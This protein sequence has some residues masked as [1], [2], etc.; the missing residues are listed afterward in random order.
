MAAVPPWLQARLDQLRPADRKPPTVAA[1]WAAHAQL[2]L[3]DLGG[4][5][6]PRGTG[7]G[8]KLVRRRSPWLLDVILLDGSQDPR[9]SGR[10][11]VCVV[12]LLDGSDHLTLGHGVAMH[13]SSLR[14]PDARRL[15]ARAALGPGVWLLDSAL[16]VTEAALAL[17]RAGVDDTAERHLQ[18]RGSRHIR[19]AG[20]QLA[21]DPAT[22]QPHAVRALDE[23]LRLIAADTEGRYTKGLQALLPDAQ[24]LYEVARSAPPERVVAMQQRAEAKL[25]ALR[26]DSSHGRSLPRP[27]LVDPMHAPVSWD[28]LR[29]ALESGLSVLP[30]DGVLTVH[31]WHVAGVTARFSRRRDDGRLEVEIPDDRYL[32]STRRGGPE[33]AAAMR[34]L[35]WLE[36]DS[37]PG[38]WAS[39]RR[40]SPATAGQLAAAALDTLRSVYA[41]GR[42][43]RLAVRGVWVPRRP[44]CRCRTSL[45]WSTTR[46]DT[47]PKG[48][49]RRYPNARATVA[50]SSPRPVTASSWSTMRRKISFSTT[51]LGS[52]GSPRWSTE[53]LCSLL[54]RRA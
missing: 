8:L 40:P 48:E 4:G 6:Q 30:R 19:A 33:R 23:I 54:P 16:P 13:V 41:V 51:R 49:R 31:E 53:A 43:E 14:S 29:G 9:A 26:L 45:C 47:S 35:G 17:L 11:Y 18:E 7:A 36:P 3:D 42:P 10:L 1:L 20:W 27:A 24:Y 5:W 37:V 44:G 46:C 12:D 2:L 15:I 22:A 25:V 32:P 21:L 39:W 52:T 34:A 38:A 28:E 50:T